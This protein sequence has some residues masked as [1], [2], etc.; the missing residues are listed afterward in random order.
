M[1]A[2]VQSFALIG[3]EIFEAFYGQ[4]R[5]THRVLNVLVPEVVLN[6][7]RVLAVVGEFEAGR[8]TEHVRVNGE[9]ETS[10]V[11]STSDNLPKCR[12]CQWSLTLCHENVGRVRVVP[13]DFSKRPTRSRP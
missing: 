6:G 13:S 9:P 3:P 12:V 10:C 1:C 4:F 5:V 11:S 7:S 8:V 2:S